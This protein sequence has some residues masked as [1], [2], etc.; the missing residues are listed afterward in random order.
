MMSC[1]TGAALAKVNKSLLLKKDYCAYK[2]KA[3]LLTCLN[4]FKEA[5]LCYKKAEEYKEE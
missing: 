4:R 5:E 3:E 1:I 2:L